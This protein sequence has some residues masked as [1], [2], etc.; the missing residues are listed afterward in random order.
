[1]IDPEELSLGQLPRALRREP[2]DWARDDGERMAIYALAYRRRAQG[3]ATRA[4][5]ATALL[6]LLTARCAGWLTRSVWRR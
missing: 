1:M 5:V 4:A 6:C 2:D 3:A